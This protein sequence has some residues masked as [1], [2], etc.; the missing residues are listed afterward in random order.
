MSDQCVLAGGALLQ[1]A[2]ASGIYFR[3]YEQ[4]VSITKKYGP[5]A[6]VFDGYNDDPTLK[7]ISLMRRTADFAGITVHF[8]GRM[9]LQGMRKQGY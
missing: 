3:E 8:T 1:S 5:A 4:A 2:M 6:I 9:V 7:Y